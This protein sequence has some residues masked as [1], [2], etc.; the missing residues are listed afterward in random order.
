MCSSF[1]MAASRRLM[2]TTHSDKVAE[3]YCSTHKELVCVL[4]ILTSHEACPGKKTAQD[5]VKT[6]RQA[7]AARA[8][9]LREQEAC[10][11]KQVGFTQF[12]SSIYKNF[13]C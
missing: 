12:S 11:T 9:G 4:C 13:C 1:Q 5:V 7:L 2:C 10:L 6:E 3:I 8:S